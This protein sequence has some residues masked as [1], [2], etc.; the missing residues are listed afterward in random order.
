MLRD[1]DID[2]DLRYA[3]ME[4]RVLSG[5][6]LKLSMLTARP[7][8]RREVPVAVSATR[9]QSASDGQAPPSSSPAAIPAPV[10][11]PVP[12]VLNRKDD[13]DDDEVDDLN[14]DDGVRQPASKPSILSQNDRAGVAAAAVAN[15]RHATNVAALAAPLAV[16]ARPN[17]LSSGKFAAGRPSKRKADQAIHR[18]LE[19][20]RNFSQ[21]QVQPATQL[22]SQADV[23]SAVDDDEA[24]ALDF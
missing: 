7:A 17:A 22:S 23:H 10:V 13:D 16:S 15:P 4:R 18:G 20:F 5:L 8:Q 2:P 6:G 19:A 21:S 12:A 1:F 11:V 14:F 9:P 3:K 24:D